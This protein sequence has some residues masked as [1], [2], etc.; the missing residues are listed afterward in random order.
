VREGAG[1]VEGEEDGRIAGGVD[2][3]ESGWCDAHDGKGQIV[4]EQGLANGI[5]IG[6]EAFLPVSVGDDRDGRGSGAVVIGGNEAAGGG[7][8]AEAVIE[9]AGHE[10]AVGDLGLAAGDE[11]EAARGD[12]GEEGGELVAPDTQELEGGEGIVGAASDA[13]L[14]VS[15]ALAVHA[16][17]DGGWALGRP[18]EDHELLGMPDWEGAEHDGV[19]K[20]VD[21]GVG[22]D[23]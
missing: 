1:G 4:D 6:G 2:A 11:V 8:N 15:E 18:V 21:G 20:A 23:A 13:G 17:D 5:G 14:A 19:H 16:V 10:E 3:K 12:V 22:A 7:G 9:S